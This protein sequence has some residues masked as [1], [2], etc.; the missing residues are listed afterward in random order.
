MLQRL[1]D[2][3]GP[4]VDFVDMPPIEASSTELRRRMKLHLNPVW[5]DPDVLQ[6]IQQHGLYSSL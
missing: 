1:G 2:D 5:L 3:Y 6:Y 4:R